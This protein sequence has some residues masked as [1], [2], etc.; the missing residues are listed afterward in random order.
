MQSPKVLIA[1]SRHIYKTRTSGVESG[2][3]HSFV[4]T[5]IGISAGYENDGVDGKHFIRFQREGGGGGGAGKRPL[6]N[7]SRLSW[8]G[9]SVNMSS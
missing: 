9:L 2:A 4:F 8:T 5:V 6:L 7:L 1:V 3:R